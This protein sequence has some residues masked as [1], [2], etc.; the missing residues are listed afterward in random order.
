[1]FCLF[2]LCRFYVD[3]TCLYSVLYS[4][5]SKL[6]TNNSA[7]NIGDNLELVF[8]VQIVFYFQVQF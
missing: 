6:Y 8:C 1:M 7:V 4:A 5:L 3:Y 2:L